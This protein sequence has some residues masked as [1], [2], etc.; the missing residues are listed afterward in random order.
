MLDYLLRDHQKHQCHH[1]HYL[2][3]ATEKLSKAYLFGT[4]NEPK[5][6][7]AVFVK[8]FQG[9]LH[10]KQPK[11]E[12]IAKLFGFHSADDFDKW[13]SANA[14]WFYAIQN[15]APDLA[16]GGPNPEYPW[17]N[18]TP[19]STPCEF[20]FPIWTEVFQTGRGRQMLKVI[21]NAIRKF[22]EYA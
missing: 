11:Y 21:R 17:P 18:D 22:P 3:M 4:R 20:A 12:R 1:L 6:T 2:Q 13:R 5:K 9:L 7:H 10:E 14:K 8:F 15:L 19:S 16:N